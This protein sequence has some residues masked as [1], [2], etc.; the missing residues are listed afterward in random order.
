MTTI[1]ILGAFV[2]GVV[3]GA[4]FAGAFLLSFAPRGKYGQIDPRY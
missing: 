2:G 4:L 3:V 1:L